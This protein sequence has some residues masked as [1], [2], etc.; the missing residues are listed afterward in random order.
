MV[1]STHKRKSFRMINDKTRE[2]N[3]SKGLKRGKELFRMIISHGWRVT[4]WKLFQFFLL[5]F[6]SSFN[7]QFHRTMMTSIFLPFKIP[8]PMHQNQ[9]QKRKLSFMKTSVDSITKLISVTIYIYFPFFLLKLNYVRINERSEKNMIFA[10]KKHFTSYSHDI[11]PPASHNSL[12]KSFN[13]I[14]AKNKWIFHAI[15]WSLNLLIHRCRCV[16]IFCVEIYYCLRDDFR[17]EAR[18]NSLKMMT[19][20]GNLWWWLYGGH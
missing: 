19:H 16:I 2:E 4:T 10:Y 11:N 20:K 13:V 1:R 12:H 8:Q 15:T 14:N 18:L 6:F 9:L 5:R 3:L 7:E 17:R